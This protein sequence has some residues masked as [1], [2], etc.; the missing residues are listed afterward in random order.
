MKGQVLADFITE[1]PNGESP[2]KYFRTPKVTPEIDDT[3]EWTLFTDGALSPKGSRAG[4]VLIGP[5]GIEHTYALLL[6]FDSTNNEAEYEALL[7]GLRIAGEMG[8]QKLEA[9]Q[10]SIGGFQPHDQGSLGGGFK[11]TIYQRDGDQYQ[12][13][14]RGGQ[15]D[16]PNNLML[17]ERD[18]ARGPLQAK[19]VIREIYMGSCGMHSGPHAVVRKAMRKGYYWPTMHDDAK[20]EIQKWNGHPGTSPTSI[21]KDQ[22][23]NR[24]D[25]LL[26]QMDRGQTASQNHRTMMI[27]EELNEEEIR[28]NL[29]LL[30]ERRELD[31]IQGARVEDQGKLGPKWEGPYRVAK[32]YQNGSYKLQ[33]MEDKE[34]PR[35]WHA[36]NLRKCY[37]KG[38]FSK[39]VDIKKAWVPT[40]R[41][42]TSRR[43][44]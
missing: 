27:R 15:L 20:K 13:G 5:S 10:A 43:T 18:M 6:T 19:Y 21:W 11:Q 41:L 16:Y 8:I 40:G 1:T 29:D 26:Y 24:G 38:Q 17:G 31:A 28:L 23:H 14:E 44:T 9:K 35:T 34:V 33:T 42:A 25:R 30:M 22:I 39:D 37:L 32:A 2:E 36:I 3:S 4:L 7:A 12:C